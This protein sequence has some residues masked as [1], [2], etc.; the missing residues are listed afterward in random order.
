MAQQEHSCFGLNMLTT[1]PLEAF[2]CREVMT[3]YFFP[4]QPWDAK[5][6]LLFSTALV[7][8]A[9]ALALLTCDLGAVFELIG[10]TSAC[11]LA[12][13]L[14]PLCFL[15]LSTR[16]WK[17]VP[18]IGCVVFGFCVMGISVVQA[19]IR[20]IRRRSPF[21]V[22]L[23]L[24]RRDTDDRF[25]TMANPIPVLESGLLSSSSIDTSDPL[26]RTDNSC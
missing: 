10:A 17:T 24:A 16:S 23:V 18:A 8:G 19:V 12:Y 25:Q 1:L 2:V 11:A 20:I 26:S 4:N 3:H 15:N 7:F 14:P 21:I 5:R 22:C 13:I 9:T 6:H